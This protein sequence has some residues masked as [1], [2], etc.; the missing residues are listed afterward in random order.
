MQ[1]FSLD[2][3]NETEFEEFCYD[4][5]KSLEFTNLNWRK[6]TG[7]SSSPS[8]QGRDIEC[9]L[10]HN[11]VD[12][13]KYFETWFVECK[14]YKQGVPP[15]KLRNALN[16]AELKIPDKLVFIASNF[17]SNPTKNYIDEY[18]RERKPGFRIYLWERPDLE[19]MASGKSNLLKKYN[20]LNGFSK[21]SIMHPSHLTF[22]TSR[23][24]NSLH[25][26]FEQFD[27]LKPESREHLFHE[28]N[29]LIMGTDDFLYYDTFKKKCYEITSLGGIDERILTYFIISDTLNTWLALGDKTSIER[30]VQKVLKTL[31][32][33]R[34]VLESS[35]PQENDQA[36]L[37]FFNY[38]P[39][40]PER[41][42]VT[43]MFLDFFQQIF[44]DD[45]PERTN[46]NYD[47]YIY[48]CEQ[49]VEK[50]LIERYLYDQDK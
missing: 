14:H 10:L 17:F 16:W 4:L 28:V 25:Y 35:E 22:L 3:L 27:K 30:I 8:D 38:A 43:N 21:M 29:N 34:K 32:I 46:A 23:P 41:R 47:L 6:G 15:E 33:I 2:H 26:L 31:P 18:I 1:N 36:A 40:N 48:F 49:V 37:D 20:I 39:E 50:L 5:F 7:L 13:R 42:N 44:I 9:Q 19:Q 12:G 45:L 11:E 24:S